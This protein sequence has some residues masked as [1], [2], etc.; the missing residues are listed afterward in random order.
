MESGVGWQTL[1]R[2]DALPGIKERE[3]ERAERKSEF[4]FGKGPFPYRF[5]NPRAESSII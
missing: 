3:E 2:R 4:G 1:L 5:A